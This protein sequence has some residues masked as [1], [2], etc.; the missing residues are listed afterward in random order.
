MIG[1]SC[2]RKMPSLMA[3]RAFESAARL[4]HFTAAADELLLTQSA[5]S[6]HVR[7]LEQSLGVQLFHR[8]G[9]HV[10]LTQDGRRYMEVAADAFDRIAAATASLRHSRHAQVLTISMPPSLAIKWFTSRMAQFLEFCPGTELRIRASCQLANFDDDSIDVAIRYGRGNWPD[11]EAEQ[12]IGEQV[13]PVCSPSR[14]SRTSR[15]RSYFRYG[16]SVD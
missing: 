3:V 11:V 6:R 9:R 8:R 14:R 12:L 16:R 13:V 1:S 5:I 7:N 15:Y 10:A 4:G 2:R